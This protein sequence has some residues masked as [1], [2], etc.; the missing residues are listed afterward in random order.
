M[1]NIWLKCQSSVT[2]IHHIYEICITFGNIYSQMLYINVIHM[3]QMLYINVIHM[4]QMLYI[5]VIHMDQ[6]LY[7][8]VIHI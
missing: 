2:F 3:Y 7:I 6:V 5:N 8:N 4:Y 1:Y